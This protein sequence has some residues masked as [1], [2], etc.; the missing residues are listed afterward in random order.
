MFILVGR[1][2][3]Q[4]DLFPRTAEARRKLAGRLGRKPKP[5]RVGFVPHT[6][7]PAHEWRHPVHVTM[8]AVRL[9]PNLRSER[10]HAVIVRLFL[11]LKSRGVRVIHYSIQK[12]HLHLMVEAT[13]REQLSRKMQ[14]LFS[15]IALAV[16]KTARRRGSL[17]RDRHHRVDLTTPTQTRNALVYI[18]F[19]GRKHHAARPG[20]SVQELMWLDPKSSAPWFTDW[21]PHARPPP[22][23]VVECQESVRTIVQSADWPTSKPRTWFARAGWR[24]GG[25]PVQFTELPRTPR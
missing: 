5:D 9:A 20:V 4:M 7:R 21:D 8:R 12:T 23:L 2:A 10:V 16:N 3:K 1:R 14:L 6:K 18:L 25:G 22:R 15:R 11:A 17:F 19:N 13:D 24:R